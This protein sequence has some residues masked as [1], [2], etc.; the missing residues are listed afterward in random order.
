MSF[1]VSPEHLEKCRYEIL[2]RH[3]RYSKW[4]IPRM[5]TIHN[6][7]LIHGDDIKLITKQIIT[8]K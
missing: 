4:T 2:T 7:V 5:W 6:V 3:H 1:F 8:I